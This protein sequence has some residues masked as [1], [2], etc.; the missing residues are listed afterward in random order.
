MRI[1]GSTPHP[2]RCS[3]SR[4]SVISVE[5]NAVARTVPAEM[6]NRRLLAPEKCDEWSERTAYPGRRSKENRLSESYTSKLDLYAPE[7]LIPG[8]SRLGSCGLEAKKRMRAL[9]FW[10]LEV[11]RT[12]FAEESGSS[13]RVMFG[14]DTRWSIIPPASKRNQRNRPNT[15]PSSLGPIPPSAPSLAPTTTPDQTSRLRR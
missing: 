11:A 1:L 7:F 9:R 13:V 8:S 14:T 4:S 6:N 10:E 3:C 2:R 12:R 15:R 5:D